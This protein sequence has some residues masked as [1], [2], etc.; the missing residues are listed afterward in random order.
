MSEKKSL[1]LSTLL[2]LFSILVI[3]VMAC[4]IYIEK[5]NANKKIANLEANA[6]DMQNTIYELQGK[7]NILSNTINSNTNYQDNT[8]EQDIENSVDDEIQ[9]EDT[10]KVLVEMHINH[11]GMPGPDGATDWGTSRFI[12]SDG[13]VYEYE[14]DEYNKKTSYPQKKKLE[15]LSKELIS[16]AK[17]TGKKLTGEELKLVKDYIRNVE[18]EKENIKEIKSS[19]ESEPQLADLVVYEYFLMYN[20]VSGKQIPIDPE[21]KGGIFYESPSISKLFDIVDKYI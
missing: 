4:Y 9:G 7:I 6:T 3:I 14:Y 19:I 21:I 1:S 16:K 10:I 8:I 18:E 15:E 13:W 17:K 20:Y 5:T 12:A 11:S 2:L